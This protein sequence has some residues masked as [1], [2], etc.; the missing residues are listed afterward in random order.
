M[1]AEK[2]IESWCGGAGSARVTFYLLAL[3]HEASALFMIIASGISQ[4][5]RTIPPKRAAKNCRTHKRNCPPEAEI[6]QNKRKTSQ[7]SRPKV[8]KTF[9]RV[10][11]ENHF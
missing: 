6:K 4:T 1:P 9:V 2:L 7:F 11:S 3:G 10:A 5:L 8:I